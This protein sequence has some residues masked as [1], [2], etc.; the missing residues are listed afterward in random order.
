MFHM[1]KNVGKE[2]NDNKLTQIT[3]EY[4]EAKFKWGEQ[5][6]KII[7]VNVIPVQKKVFANNVWEVYGK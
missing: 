3:Q 6:K 2:S 1:V 7:R 4:P 5:M